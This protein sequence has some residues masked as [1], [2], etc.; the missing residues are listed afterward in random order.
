MHV[1]ANC[2]DRHGRSEIGFGIT[3]LL[4]YYLLPR[5]KRINTVKLYWPTAGVPDPYPR[6]A[7]AL[8][9][10]IR[11]KLIAQQYDRMIKYATAIR[12]RTASTATIPR[13]FTRDASH[14]PTRPCWR[15]A[16]HGRPSSSPAVRGASSG[17]RTGWNSGCTWN[18]QAITWKTQATSLR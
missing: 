17:R 3:R 2:T 10:P 5:I 14:P 15:S 6:L 11:W 7:L 8:T 9:R 1:E 12:R 13:R 18:T 4:N 16:V